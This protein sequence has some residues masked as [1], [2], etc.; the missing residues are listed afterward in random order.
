MMS[1]GDLLSEPRLILALRFAVGSI[2]VAAGWGKMPRRYELLRLMRDQAY[3]PHWLAYP[4]SRFLPWVELSLGAALLLGIAPL[5]MSSAVFGLL[6]VFTGFLIRARLAGFEE[7]DCNCFGA[8]DTAQRTT[9]LIGRNMV[10]IA[11]TSLLVLA[12]SAEASSSTSS[13]PL[14]ETMTVLF[15][16]LGLFTALQLVRGALRATADR[17][18][19]E[20]GLKLMST[21]ES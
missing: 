14:A 13:V 20:N 12:L 1:P 8:T 4:V 15:A 9:L 19:V 21:P 3:L 10:F 7:L 18:E 11:L 5:W 16:T 17:R 6:V 2:V